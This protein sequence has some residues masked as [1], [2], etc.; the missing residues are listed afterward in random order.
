MRLVRI[1][2]I[3]EAVAALQAGELVIVPTETVYGLAADA[4][5]VAAVQ[6]V[7]EAKGRPA[8]NPLIVHVAH[9]DQAR[10]LALTWPRFAEVLAEKF[11]PGPLTLVVAKKPVIGDLVTAGRPTVAVRV[12]SHE[13]LG[14][15]LRLSGLSLA[16]PSA[17][18]FMGVSPTCTEMLDENLVR[19]V[20]GVLEGGRCEIGIESTVVDCTGPMPVV[21]REGKI[22]LDDLRKFVPEAVRADR[23]QISAAP[24][25]HARHYAPKTPLLLVD[26][27]GDEPG[28]VFGPARVEGQTGTPEDPAEYMRILYFTLYEQDQKG[29]HEIYWECPPPSVEWSAVLDRLRRASAQEP[30]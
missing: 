7:F 19:K 28:V 11:W 22:T 8:N 16:A 18:P 23:D 20:A 4:T 21:L 13:V 25:Q 9:L 27:L 5:D 12:P 3:H 26:D 15:V 29:L 24:G 10:E 2:T 17:N 14:E 6:K 30:G 1:L